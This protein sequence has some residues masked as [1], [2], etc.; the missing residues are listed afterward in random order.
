MGE[1]EYTARQYAEQERVMRMIRWSRQT[2]LCPVCQVQPL[3]VWPDGVVRGTCGGR[4]CAE[5]WLNIRPVVRRR[6]QAAPTGAKVGVDSCDTGADTGADSQGDGF[7]V[8]L[9]MG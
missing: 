9:V 6:E 2:G 7:V 1:M 8:G 4:V 3:G 5:R